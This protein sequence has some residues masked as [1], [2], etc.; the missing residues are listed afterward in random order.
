MTD[1]IYLQ[2]TKNLYIDADMVI[3]IEV[4]EDSVAITSGSPGAPMEHVIPY[5]ESWYPALY[6]F[7]RYAIPGMREQ[8]EMT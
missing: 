4:R 2:M 3:S 7:Y 1:N 5:T 6:D 8:P